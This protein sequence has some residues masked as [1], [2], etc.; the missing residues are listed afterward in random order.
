MERVRGLPAHLLRLHRAV[1]GRHPAAAGLRHVRGDAGLLG[2]HVRGH[3][4]LP[5][6]AAKLPQLLHQRHEC[7]DGDAVDSRRRLQ[8]RLLRDEQE[9]GS[10]LGVQFGPDPDR[11]GHPAAGHFLQPRHTG[12]AWLST[13]ATQDSGETRARVYIF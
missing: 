4:G 11:R 2:R 5:T 3:A 1:C 6:A 8:D 9:P 7:E 12:Q 13:T 10:V